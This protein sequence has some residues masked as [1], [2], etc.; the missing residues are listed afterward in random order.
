M[1]IIIFALMLGV[2]ALGTAEIAISGLLPVVSQD[3]S[4]SLSDAG[5]LITGYALG[6]TI[7]GPIV[8]LFTTRVPR[9]ALI[10]SLL[11]TFIL[12]NIWTVLA[13]NYQMLM[14]SRIFTSLSHGTFVAVAFSLAVALSPPDKPGS[15]IA[16]V[17]LGFNLA[18]A[19]GAPLGTF[20]GQ[21]LGWRS[22]FLVIVLMAVIS[23]LLIIAF[24]RSS[25]AK[26]EQAVP[27][28]IRTE[29][30][31]LKNPYILLA[32]ITTVIAQG[33]VFTASTYVVP[34]L[35]EVSKFSLNS[36]SALLIIFGIGAICGNFIGG[37]LADQDVTRGVVIVLSSLTVVLIVFWIT[38]TIPLLSV[39]TLFFF[40]A[41]GFSII[42]SLQARMQS[43]AIAAPTLALS[44][45]VSAFNLGNGLGAW[46]GG[47]VLNF[48]F[49][50]R[51]IL[52]AAAI[53]AL[54]SLL[55]TV[56]LNIRNKSKDG[57][58][59]NVNKAQT[60]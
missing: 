39:I 57:L 6:V 3:L 7:V 25:A 55:I 38:S 31:V 1:Q 51:T 10:I 27:A 14:I 5:F 16:K 40:G 34:I 30:Q 37:R 15:G 36:I 11:G 21:H 41:I 50:V 22:T 59:L 20:I 47:T 35:M 9:K 19:L 17:A 32:L 13:P 33:A 56:F 29:L 49:N 18:N 45:N 52:L 42:P 8:T 28:N 54:I 26:S 12:G 2:F 60:Y 24:M 44:I 58:N 4:I 46:V 53:L 23:V 43:I 48:G